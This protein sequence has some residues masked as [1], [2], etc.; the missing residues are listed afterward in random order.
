M[1]KKRNLAARPAPPTPNSNFD[2]SLSGREKDL[3]EFIKND[4]DF[5]IKMQRIAKAQLKNFEETL[6]KGESIKLQDLVD[7]VKGYSISRDIIIDLV[8]EIY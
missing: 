4:F 1:A 8:R 3:E 6:D 5:A 2:K 7:T